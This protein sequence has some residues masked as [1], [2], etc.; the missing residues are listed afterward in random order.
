MGPWEDG[1]SRHLVTRDPDLPGTDLNTP[2]RRPA[3]EGVKGVGMGSQGG[4][5]KG[6]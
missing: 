3:G 5:V 2:G 4:G 6:P 1:L